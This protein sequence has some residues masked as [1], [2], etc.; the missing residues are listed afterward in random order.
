MSMFHDC[1]AVLEIWE[2]IDSVVLSFTEYSEGESLF[3]IVSP[4]D[5]VVAKERDQDD[6]IEWLLEKKK[7]EVIIRSFPSF[8]LN[9]ASGKWFSIF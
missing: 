8:L 2:E 1:I 4:S 9:G 7:Y 3:Y 6:H 5:V